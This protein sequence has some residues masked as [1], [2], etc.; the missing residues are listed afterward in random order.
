MPEYHDQLILKRRPKEIRDWAHWEESLSFVTLIGSE[1]VI[2]E[3]VSMQQVPDSLRTSILKP[4]ALEKIRRVN[5]RIGLDPDD[6]DRD[7]KK[8]ARL[9]TS[10]REICNHQTAS[11]PPRRR[12]FLGLWK[13]EAH[14]QAG[15]RHQGPPFIRWDMPVLK[16]K[17]RGPKRD[18]E[19]E[20]RLPGVSASRA[21]TLTP[22]PERGRQSQCSSKRGCH[23]SGYGGAGGKEAERGQQSGDSAS[24][25]EPETASG[26]PEV[27]RDRP[28]GKGN[29]PT[30]L[31][32][33]LV[34][35][36]KHLK[37]FSKHLK[38]G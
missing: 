21:R 11:P 17:K 37:T 6:M 32:F 22:S 15:G 4:F 38:T 26:K 33:E 30:S 7:R 35:L 27:P 8:F 12:D 31:S 19:Q 24:V 23:R 3:H 1:H 5:D 18:R 34:T 2:P 20:D 29:V 28:R 16:G 13:E 9:K 14:R 10:D 36:S 25:G